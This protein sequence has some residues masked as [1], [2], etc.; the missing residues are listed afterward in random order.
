[1]TTNY[2]YLRSVID[3]LEE[4][5][6]PPGKRRAKTNGAATLTEPLQ[7]LGSQTTPWWRDP[8][9]IPRREFLFGRHYIRGCIGA[10][11]GAGGRAKTT[12]GSCEAVGMA[13]GRDLMT[14]TALASGPLRVW[15][16]QGEEDQNE[17]DR[18]FAATCQ[19]YGVTEADLGGRL[20]VKSVCERPM[21]LAA[22]VKTVPTL[23]QGVIN[24]MKAL[25]VANQIDVFM[26]DPFISFHAVNES[27][28]MDMD[29]VLK[30]ALGSLAKATN[31]AGEIFHHP[32]KPKPGQ[33]TTVEDGR[34][35]SAIIWAVRS[36]RVLNF[37]TPEEANKI[38]IAETDRRRHIRITNGKANMGPV[39]A[40]TWIRIEL[41][42]LPN[43]DEIACGSLWTPPNPFDGVT[44][45]DAKVA[46]RLSKGGAFRADVQSP[47]WFGW[48]LAKHL[49]INVK[50]GA[51]NA[52]KDMARIK[53][54]IKTWVKNKVLEIDKREDDRRREKSFIVPGPVRMEGA[55][56]DDDA[57]L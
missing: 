53:E 30:D 6:A 54:I 23:N 56:D 45:E 51:E 39:G 34:G 7:D 11:I 26:L 44:A 4:T 52:P 38:G 3:G 41:E 18:R 46:Q 20:F 43:G 19:H 33:E 28:N 55:Y 32:G 13:I 24:E 1:M 12:L 29:M 40:S 50:H 15:V 25:I 14:G 2:E 49:K 37:M 21:R 31:S 57:V 47:Q 17:L 36:A 5:I 10:T 22:L 42:P 16:L 8:A 48:E 27:A 9:T 35:A